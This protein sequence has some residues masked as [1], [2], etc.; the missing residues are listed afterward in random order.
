MNVTLS[1]STVCSLWRVVCLVSSVSQLTHLYVICVSLQ[2]F[3]AALARWDPPE[4]AMH[5][6]GQLFHRAS[7]AQIAVCGAPSNYVTV[8][9][10][11]SLIFAEWFSSGLAVLIMVQ[12]WEKRA[13]FPGLRFRKINTRKML[14][15]ASW[16]H[17]PFPSIKMNS[18]RA[19]A[20]RWPTIPMCP[21]VA[22]KSVDGS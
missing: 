14:S 17:C 18:Q 1:T 8:M 15:R 6:C 16:C 2:I 20:L 3:S 5:G 19:N 7:W 13:I 11:F 12:T 9:V 10:L 4:L 22:C 21:I